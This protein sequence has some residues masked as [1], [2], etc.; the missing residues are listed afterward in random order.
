M[1]EYELTPEERKRRSDFLKRLCERDYE[2][3]NEE[4]D[5]DQPLKKKRRKRKIKSKDEQAPLA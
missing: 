4:N 2:V 5:K 1:S 3:F